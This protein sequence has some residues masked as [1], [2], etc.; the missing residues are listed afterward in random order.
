[1]KKYTTKLFNLKGVIIDKVDVKKD[2]L[3]YVRNPRRWAQCPLCGISSRKIHQR[4]QRKVKHGI[5]NEKEVFLMVLV[6]RF[7]CKKCSKPFTEKHIPGVS[8]KRHTK[9]LQKS[10]LKDLVSSSFKSVSER[11]NISSPALLGFL[12]DHKSEPLW[13]DKGE[14]ILNVDEH[15]YSG[16]D[17]KISIGDYSNKNLLFVLPDAKQ[18]SLISFL[19]NM[20]KDVKKKGF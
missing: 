17:M 9:Q 8:R 15:S 14:I 12:K 20:P 10:V 7:K 4:K 3:I 11:Y 13:P 2:V 6:R 18:S 16:R 1:M 5:L 19:K